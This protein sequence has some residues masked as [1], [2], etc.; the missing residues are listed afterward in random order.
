MRKKLHVVFVVIAFAILAPIPP[1]GAQ[2]AGTMPRIGFL[3]PGA[4]RTTASCAHAFREGLRE[5]GWVDGQNL[6]IEY[7]W[8]LGQ[9]DRLPEFAADLVRLQVAVIFA[10]NTPAV[11]AVK[12][13]GTQLPV[14][15][16]AVSEPIEI[17]AVSS[18]AR[19]G[20]TFT[21][22]TTMNRE[23]MPKRL[24]L[25]KEATPGLTRVGYLANPTYA[26]HQPQL[27]EMQAAARSLGIALHLFEVREGSELERAFAGMAAAHVGAFI[28]QQDA[29]FASHR[30]TIIALAAQ[31]RLPGMYPGSFYPD[32]GRLISYAAHIEDLCRRTATYVDKILKGAQPA[33]LPVERPL[34]FELVINL[35][36]AKALGLT[37]PPRLLFQADKVIQ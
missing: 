2:Q 11:L 6:A 34:K 12:Q 10:V 17:G 18:L 23:L 8:A 15:F 31:S 35:K 3:G 16:A 29:L 9:L 28:V 4:P 24:E 7:R 1:A 26:G 30:R 33:D 36:T 32:E 22:L 14:V 27:H 19:P 5:H 25:L 13:T 20:G 21:G 37:I